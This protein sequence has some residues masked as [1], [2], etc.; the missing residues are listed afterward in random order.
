M[1]LHTNIDLLELI[2]VCGQKLRAKTFSPGLLSF[3]F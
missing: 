2:G 1:K 3:L